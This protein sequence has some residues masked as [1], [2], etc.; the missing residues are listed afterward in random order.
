[1]SHSS[2]NSLILQDYPCDSS[3]VRDLLMENLQKF[4]SE[5]KK[6][7]EVNQDNPTTSNPAFSIT[8]NEDSSQ[9]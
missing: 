4:M 9:G 6:K 3:P 1:M 8:S 7:K 5:Q 2:Q